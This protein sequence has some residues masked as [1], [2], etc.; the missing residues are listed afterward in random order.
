MLL[1]ITACFCGCEQ[2]ALNVCLALID[3]SIRI[4]RFEGVKWGTI[5][6]AL[7]NGWIIGRFSAFYE[8]HFSFYDC[9][10]WRKYFSN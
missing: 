8:K 1:D 9:F 7:I 6:C 10:P 5:L 3:Y 4:W 2:V